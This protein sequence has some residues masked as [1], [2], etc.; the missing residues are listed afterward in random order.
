MLHFKN[1]CKFLTQIN[2]RSCRKLDDIRIIYATVNDSV[3]LSLLLCIP[4]YLYIFR[5]Y[6]SLQVHIVGMGRKYCNQTYVIVKLHKYNGQQYVKI[7]KVIL[8]NALQFALKQ[9]LSSGQNLYIIKSVANCVVIKLKN[10]KM[11]GFQLLGLKNLKDCMNFNKPISQTIK[12][13]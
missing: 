8:L 6:Q 7:S 3:M 4:T 11:L 9:K 1:Q 10:A 5:T 13:F 2:R 12:I